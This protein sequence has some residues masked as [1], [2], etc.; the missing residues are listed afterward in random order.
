M[1]PRK[2]ELAAWGEAALRELRGP[3]VGEVRRKLAQWRD[4]RARLLRK[5]KRARQNATAGTVGTGVLGVGA[6]GA[7]AP[8]AFGL[9]VGAGALET[10][11]D[12]A[13]F[14]VG[15]VAV[16][17]AFGTVAEWRR[18]RRLLRT[19]LPEAAPEPV[20]LPPNG[21]QAREPMRLL[22][23]AEQSLHQAL[24]QLGGGGFEE[25]TDARATADRAATALREVASRLQA[26]E[27]ALPHVPAT[28]QADLRAD[29]RR[30]RAELDEG[31]EGYRYLVAA[32]GR[33]VAASGAPEQR[34]A[35]QDATDRLAGL[36]TALHELGWGS[37]TAGSADQPR[38]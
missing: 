14:G 16:A 10:M 24:T 35:V 5:R 2:N 29:V 37:G 17:A 7:Y 21:S 12:V 32:A 30:L 31:V 25:A 27:A 26:V 8:H 11:L 15:G 23:D 36:A 3:V 19:P 6:Y 38:T 20:E 1:P 4:P 9:P 28:E 22:R 13:A 33:A 34:H 18:Y